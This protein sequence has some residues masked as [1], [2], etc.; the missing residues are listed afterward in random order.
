MM[1]IKTVTQLYYVTDNVQQHTATGYVNVC[2]YA[3]QVHREPE[4]HCSEQQEVFTVN[5]LQINF[6]LTSAEQNCDVC[7]SRVCGCMYVYSLAIMQ[8]LTGC[9]CL[10]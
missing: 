9:H 5:W 6:L 7:V 2:Q 4:L 10:V 1:M 3:W 8:T